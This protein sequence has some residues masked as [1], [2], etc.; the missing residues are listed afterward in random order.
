VKESWTGKG[1]YWFGR[2]NRQYRTRIR[3]RRYE[4]YLV[5]RSFCL[6]VNS[7]SSQGFFRVG[8]G[9]AWEYL[10]FSAKAG[11]LGW[12]KIRL[13]DANIAGEFVVEVESNALQKSESVR[14]I[15]QPHPLVQWR[16]WFRCP[17]CQKRV[18][19]LFVTLLD[20]LFACRECHR[21]VYWSQMRGKRRLGE[22]EYTKRRD[23]FK[24]NKELRRLE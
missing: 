23:L 24:V 6:D 16:Y 22:D 15:Y 13:V 10:C 2:K 21:L 17:T 18:A 8:R 20:S 19:T 7:L 12:A 14:V 9:P 11:Y 1:L 3:P 5:E 4:N